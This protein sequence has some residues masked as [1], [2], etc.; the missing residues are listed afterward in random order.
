MIKQYADVEFYHDDY[1][2]GRPGTVPDNDFSYWS[3]IAT[4]KI[5]NRTFGRADKMDNIPEEVRM[6]CCEVAEKLYQ[7]EAVR[8]DNGMILQSYGNDG[9]TATYKTDDLSEA[10]VGQAVD[11]IIR[12]WLS[13]TGLMYCGVCK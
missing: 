11:G 3:M 5:R 10:A 7:S 6:C 2:M 8:A 12:R 13:L 1:L 9:D 4:A